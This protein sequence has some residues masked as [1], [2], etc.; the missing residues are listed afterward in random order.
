[1][2]TCCSSKNLLH[3]KVSI[4]IPDEYGSSIVWGSIDP[5]V[6][7]ILLYSASD[8]KRIEKQH[9]QSLAAI[10]VYNHKLNSTKK[11]LY[12]NEK[13]NHENNF[14]SDDSELI[15]D[16]DYL[17]AEDDDEYLEYIAELYTRIKYYED[18]LKIAC[19]AS[20]YL[21]IFE[22]VT[23]VFNNGKPYQ[24]TTAG[25]HSSVFRFKLKSNQTIIRKKV[26][27][28]QQYDAWYLIENKTSHIGFLVDTSNSLQSTVIEKGIEEFVEKQKELQ[29]HV[30]FYGATFSNDFANVFHAV[31]LKQTSTK[32][33]KYEFLNN[34]SPEA[35]SISSYYD[36]IVTMIN[37]ITPNYTINDEVTICIVVNKKTDTSSKLYTCND[38]KRKIEYKQKHGWNIIMVGLNNLNKNE[39]SDCYGERCSIIN[40]GNTT[41]EV[42]NTFSSVCNS[43]ERVRQGIDSKIQ[44][45]DI[46]L[47]K[48]ILL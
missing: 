22:G 32:T 26:E 12:E 39:L 5:L 48:S 37:S 41:E 14:D 36:A 29:H 43:V 45:N 33:I 38:M 8:S 18:Q 10:R 4:S 34:I 21:N 17:S 42:C 20:I 27:F 13:K 44:F 7:S 46:E 31:D 16:N 23:I 6:G 35:S 9:T 25:G 40:T 28:N 19:C 47:Q 2:N 3:K 30:M 11:E 15:D 1:M 24:T